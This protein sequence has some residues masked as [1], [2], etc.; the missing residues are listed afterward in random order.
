M[1]LLAYGVGHNA[2]LVTI[3]GNAI[4][5]SDHYLADKNEPQK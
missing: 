1:A 2:I 3:T 5:N 4:S